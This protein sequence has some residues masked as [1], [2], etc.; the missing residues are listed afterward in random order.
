VDCDE[1][2][3]PDDEPVEVSEVEAPELDPLAVPSDAEVPVAAAS[4]VVV[5]A[6]VAE[7]VG[8]TVESAV[9]DVVVVVAA[10]VAEDP[11]TT[12][13]AM[14]TTAPALRAATMAV[15]T[16]V[17]SHIFCR[18]LIGASFRWP[19][20]HDRRQEQHSPIRCAVSAMSMRPLCDRGTVDRERIADIPPA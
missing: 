10:S 16:R 18:A 20:R 4:S 12:P 17:R 1:E 15:A 2:T 8:V 5:V 3:E 11:S 9:S 7:G 19:H 14:T 6:V 13:A